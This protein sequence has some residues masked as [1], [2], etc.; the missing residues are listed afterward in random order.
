M[1][2][3]LNCHHCHLSYFTESPTPPGLYNVIFLDTPPSPNMD[4]VIYEQPLNV[5]SSLQEGS[6]YRTHS[7]NL[8]LPNF[9][10]NFTRVLTKSV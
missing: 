9:L 4:D 6:V 2:Y 8:S 10:L 3:S 7:D 1:D 5:V